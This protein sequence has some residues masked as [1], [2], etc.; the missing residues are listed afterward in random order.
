MMRP[1]GRQGG[2]RW[3]YGRFTMG[4]L[5]V[6]LA[7][8]VVL[9][10]GVMASAVQPN[11]LA[12]EATPAAG[13]ME[14][15]SFE[16]VTFAIGAELMNPAD[17]FVIRIGLE[18]GTVLPNDE[19]DPSVG[20][21]I[22]ESGTFTMEIP[23]PVTVTRGAGLMDALAAAEA[24]GDLSGAMETVSAGEVIT[25]EVGDAAYVPANVAGEIRNEGQE[26]AVG[27]GILVSP[28]MGMMAEATPAP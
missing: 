6:L 12:Q 18:P 16:P 5:S 25:L 10:L 1:R 3:E 7:V 23:A 24:S 26:R 2:G 13:E 19:N 27:L 8:A 15:I 17:I 28:S 9:L 22:V 21:L 20:I 14:G 11:V 4:R